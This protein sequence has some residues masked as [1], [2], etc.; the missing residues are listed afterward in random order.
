MLENLVAFYK[1][2]DG[3]T[4]KKILACIFSE[5]ITFDENKD[6]AISFA[7]PI[8]ILVKSSKGLVRGKKEK[9]VKNDLLSY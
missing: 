3:M 5:K 7:T 2:A 4:K 1:K 8:S 9:E 6:A